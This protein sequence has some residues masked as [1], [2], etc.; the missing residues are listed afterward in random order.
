MDHPYPWKPY[1][2]RH[3]SSTACA[4]AAG[5][6]LQSGCVHAHLKARIMLGE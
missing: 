3:G 2:P 1:L 6:V 5:S 4:P